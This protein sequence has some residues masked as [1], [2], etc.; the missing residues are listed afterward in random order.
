VTKFLHASSLASE[1]RI[2]FKSPFVGPVFLSHATNL[3]RA[4][5]TISSIS[6]AKTSWN[7]MAPPPFNDLRLKLLSRT[8]VPGLKVDNS[9]A[10]CS[11]SRQLRN[12]ARKL[13]GFGFLSHCV[14]LAAGAMHGNHQ[15]GSGGVC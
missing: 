4:R 9:L 8:A 12:V 6:C 1:A 15:E 11:I 13:S 2:I 3:A 7:C 5:L 10:Q 14:L